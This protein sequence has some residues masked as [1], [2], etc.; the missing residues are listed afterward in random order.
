[1]KKHTFIIGATTSILL[2][3]ACA[4][5]DTTVSAAP[6]QHRPQPAQN[7]ASNNNLRPPDA[8]LIETYIRT[9]IDIISPIPPAFG[10]MFSVSSVSW[11]NDHVAIVKYTD[12]QAKLTGRVNAKFKNGKVLIDSFTTE[13]F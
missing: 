8:S 3:S 4:K 12:G 13:Q 6:Q 7:I 1:M 10:G 9:Y 2:L 11:V 5:H